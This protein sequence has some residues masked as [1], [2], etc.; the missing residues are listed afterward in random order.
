MQPGRFDTWQVEYSPQLR[1][2]S[3]ALENTSLSLTLTLSSLSLGKH[4]YAFGKW[5]LLRIFWDCAQMLIV[6]SPPRHTWHGMGLLKHLA[7]FN[8]NSDYFWD[9]LILMPWLRFCLLSLL[10]SVFLLS[11]TAVCLC[12]Q[13]LMD[14]WKFLIYGYFKSSFSGYLSTRFLNVCLNLVLE[15]T[16]A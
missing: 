15:D 6:K 9:F 1:T 14:I 16:Y 8:P 5:E 12:A 10:S 7:S 3:Q 4:R 2:C 13:L 11:Y